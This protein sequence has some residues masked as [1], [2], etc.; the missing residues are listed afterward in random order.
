ML[1]GRAG[2]RTFST[3][4]SINELYSLSPM[5]SFQSYEIRVT[6]LILDIRKRKLK[7]IKQLARGRASRN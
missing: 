3:V 2:E 1:H 7:E 5:S 6:I 4:A